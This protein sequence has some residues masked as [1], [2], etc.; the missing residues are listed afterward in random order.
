MQQVINSALKL[1]LKNQNSINLK[2]TSGGGHGNDRLCKLGL[3]NQINDGKKKSNIN[4]ITFV[5]QNGQIYEYYLKHVLDHNF[6]KA[7]IIN[8]S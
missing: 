2:K 5:T 3:I 8:L 6:S 1:Q 4:I 7:S